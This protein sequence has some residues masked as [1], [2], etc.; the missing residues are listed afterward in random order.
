MRSA[1]F[2]IFWTSATDE[3]PYF[4][5]TMGKRVSSCI[6]ATLGTVP[7]IVAEGT[8]RRQG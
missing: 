7:A 1:T 2:C 3:P 5:T 8:S 6:L 4:W